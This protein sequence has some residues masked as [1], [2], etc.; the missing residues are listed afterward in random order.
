MTEA[1]FVGPMVVYWKLVERRRW[2]IGPRELYYENP[3]GGQIRA[4]SRI[5]RMLVEG[6]VLVGPPVSCPRGS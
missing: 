1:G 4:R 2:L 5:G 3:R 6:R